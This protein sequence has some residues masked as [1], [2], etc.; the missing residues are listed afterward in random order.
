[1][2]GVRPRA[3][4]AAGGPAGR[5]SDRAVIRQSGLTGL[6]AGASVLV[7]LLLDITIAA[8]FGAGRETDSF[9]VAA[10][11]PLGLVAVVMVVCNQVMVPA[12]NTAM[13]KQGHAATSRL[14]S[15][16][17]GAILV[18][19]ALFLVAASLLAPVLI[20]VTAPGISAAEVSTAASM[21][22]VIFAI[23]PLIAISEVMRAYCNA[24]YAFIAPALMNVVLSGLA[25]TVV[26]VGPRHI[27]NVVAWGYLVGAVAQ[28]TF[29]VGMA[30]RRGLR[31]RPA[32]DLRNPELRAVGTLSLRP[33][34]AAGCNPVAR[35]GEQLMVSFLPPGSIT[36]LNYGYRLISAIGGTIFFRS[37]VVALV[38][39]LTEAHVRGDEAEV[40]RITGLGMRI[41]LALSVPLTV[42][43]AILAKPAALVVFQRGNFTHTSASLL[44]VVLAVYSISL[45]GSALQRV[46][47]APFFARLDTRTPLRNTVYGVLANLAMLPLL[48]LPFGWGN[49]NAIIGIALAY[50]LAQFVNVL[51]ARHRLR[52][53]IGRPARGLARLAP[54][55]VAASA[56]SGAVM[57]AGVLVLKLDDTLPRGT[58][59]LRT[60]LTGLTGALILGAAM[61]LLAGHDLSTTWRT[62]RRRQP[63]TSLAADAESLS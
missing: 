1:M 48:T 43:L 32:F 60:A 35:L 42:F 62:L 22:P 31:L 17:V 56:V 51:H 3:V 63:A 58:L 49:P 9:F 39:R 11:I 45:V 15:R 16:I 26:L 46:L 10:R 41:M 12:F 20:R 29:M 18:A 34:V 8:R 23:V 19:G 33:F 27:I 30:T 50:S 44:G 6:A 13:T 61:L 57:I 2:G 52:R 7:G 40:L 36:I 24:R 14:V 28:T 59:L 54:R 21:V 25:A 37:V 53:T 55:L 38:P 4:V 5:H 47:L